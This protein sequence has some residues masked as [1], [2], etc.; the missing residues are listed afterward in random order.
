M[1]QYI[2]E[3]LSFQKNLAL[4]G[5]AEE[6]KSFPQKNGEILIITNKS[7]LK[8]RNRFFYEGY[9]KGYNRK[10]V[11]DITLAKNGQVKNPDQKDK[12]GFYVGTY[13]IDKYIYNIWK[14]MERRCYYPNYPSYEN[15]GAKGITVSDSFKNY[16][17]FETWYK[18]IW[19]GKTKLE[20]DKDIKSNGEC[21]IYSPETCILIPSAINTFISTLGENKGIEEV[22]NK[23]HTT[24][25]VHYR[26][27][28][29]K[30]NKNFKKLEDAKDFRKELD[31][32]YI[33]TL[34]SMYQLPEEI[35]NLI[36][37]YVEVQIY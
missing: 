7:S 11:F 35:K 12:Y 17:F 28:Y 1:T 26:R 6:I 9:F 30:V 25:C 8:R 22:H 31:K 29:K 33:E 10:L 27:K 2:K 21:K 16:V 18:A 32:V 20:L 3:R 37:K 4:S 23:N 5:I 13:M 24:Y 19:D 15:Y 14:N 36:R 34:F